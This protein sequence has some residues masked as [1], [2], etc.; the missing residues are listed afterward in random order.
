MKTVPESKSTTYSSIFLEI[1]RPANYIYLSYLMM[2]YFCDHPNLWL[3]GSNEHPS[4]IW[5]I[6]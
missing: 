1:S 4:L 3:D 5:V 2:D 6:L